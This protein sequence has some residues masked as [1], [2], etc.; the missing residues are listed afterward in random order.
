MTVRRILSQFDP[1]F[2]WLHTHMLSLC[3]E[4][5]TRIV[6]AEHMNDSSFILIATP[7]IHHTDEE[8]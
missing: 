2:Q 1:D 8:L 6:I 4:L 5:N 7:I 3:K